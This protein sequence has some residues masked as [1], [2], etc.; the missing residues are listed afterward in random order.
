MRRRAYLF[1]H[2]KRSGCAD[3]KLGLK[4]LCT[5]FPLLWA[6][7]WL[8][9]KIMFFRATASS[10]GKL[11]GRLPVLVLLVIQFEL[12]FPTDRP[13]ARPLPTHS[14]H[15]LIS[16]LNSS[17]YY[18]PRTPSHEALIFHGLKPVHKS[19]IQGSHYSYISVYQVAISQYMRS[20]VFMALINIMDLWV[21]SSRKWAGSCSG[22]RRF[23]MKFARKNNEACRPI[24]G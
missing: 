18:R 11:T 19:R 5:V 14:P 23:K 3:G 17:F 4:C 8:A 16:A 12:V 1:R 10:T 7:G 20:D 22:S 9:R 21:R 2:W 13:I 15:R 6:S 24:A